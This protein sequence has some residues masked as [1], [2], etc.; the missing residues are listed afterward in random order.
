M[1]VVAHSEAKTFEA[2][3]PLQ[4]RARLV[5]SAKRY[6]GVLLLALRSPTVV[7]V[8]SESKACSL[9]GRAS[10]YEAAVANEARS[11]GRSER[12]KAMRALANELVGVSFWGDYIG[13]RC[14]RMGAGQHIC[15][16]VLQREVRVHVYDVRVDWV[17]RVRHRQRTAVLVQALESGPLLHQD[18]VHGANEQVLAQDARHELLDDLAALDLEGGD[19]AEDLAFGREVRDHLPRAGPR[20]AVGL[21]AAHLGHLCRL[22][23]LRLVDQALPRRLHF[24]GA[25]RSLDEAV[26]PAHEVALESLQVRGW[27]RQVGEVGAGGDLVEVAVDHSTP[28]NA[29]ASARL[30]HAELLGEGNL[31]DS[32][33]QGD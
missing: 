33:H 26:A 22:L 23:R 25:E 28:L 4:F 13:A 11:R 16:A 24:T 31:S 9:P 20:G 18:A 6:V 27:P 3:E 5:Q 2:K 7:H 15:A 1:P 30:A 32:C 8:V 14:I 21:A 17:G 12:D 29:G 19:V 10:M